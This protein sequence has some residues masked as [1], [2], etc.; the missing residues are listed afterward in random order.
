MRDLLRQNIDIAWTIARRDLRGRFSRSRLGFVWLFLNPLLM[1]AVYVGVFW[2]VLGLQWHHPITGQA[3]GYI[4]PFFSGLVVYLLIADLTVSSLNLF[5]AKRDYV[6]KSPFPLW[7]L[8]LANLFR[9]G[10]QGLG[11]LVVLIGLALATGTLDL[12]NALWSVPTIFLICAFAAAFSLI[13]AMIGCFIGDLADAAQLLLRVLFYAAPI[14]YPSELVPASLRWVQAINPLTHL[15]EPLR[16]PIA[17]GLAPSWSTAFFSL[18]VAMLMGLA[19]WFYVRLR[20]AVA[21]VV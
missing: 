20:G 2:G 3:I 13:L 4:T 17:F 12:P 14:T 8:W 16:N 1:S 19:A 15:V 11:N 6:L 9:A 21:D 7:V 18:G 10:V 5:V